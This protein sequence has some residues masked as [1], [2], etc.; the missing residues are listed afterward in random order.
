MNTKYKLFAVSV[1]SLMF[2]SACTG[3]I[4]KEQADNNIQGDSGVIMEVE[5]TAMVSRYGNNMSCDL[6]KNQDDRL[7]CLLQINE[8]IGGM[9]ES[10][11]LSSFDINRCEDLPVEVAESCK[12]VIIDSGVTGPVSREE[13]SLY[14]KILQG[15]QPEPTDNDGLGMIYPEYNAEECANL[16]APGYKE[17]CERQIAD[18]KESI[19]LEKIIQ[20]KDVSRCDELKDESRKE[21]CEVIM[22]PVLS[23]PLDELVE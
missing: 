19:L 10:E 6:L 4:T 3:T 13:Q 16:K 11:I 2:F 23:V 21:S 15:T 8:M 20:S 1:L 14:S 18:R 12:M 5:S 17:Y 7:G 9:L 22:A